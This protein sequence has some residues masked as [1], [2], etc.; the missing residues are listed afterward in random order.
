MSKSANGLRIAYGNYG[1]FIRKKKSWRDYF[2]IGEGDNL[3]TWNSL[4][5]LTIN[6]ANGA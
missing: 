6:N 5:P 4:R 2:Q 3:G 1:F